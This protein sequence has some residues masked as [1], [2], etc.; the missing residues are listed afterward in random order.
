MSRK[1]SLAPLFLAAVFASVPS[2]VHAQTSPAAA[3]RPWMNTALNP[4]QR[5]DLVL[6]ELTLP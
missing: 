2:L 4:D 1:L 6:K 3:N 5:A